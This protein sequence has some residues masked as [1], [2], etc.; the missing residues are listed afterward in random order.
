MSSRR[1]PSSSSGPG[2]A[3]PTDVALEVA[4]VA[5]DAARQI[6]ELAAIAGGLAMQLHGYT[7]NTKDVDVVATRN[8]RL[9]G[10][11]RALSF[12]G[13][14]FAVNHP[15]GTVELDVIV[16]SDDDAELYAA[17]AENATHI[18]GCRVVRPDYLAIMKM[19]AHRPKDELDFDY[20]A[21][22]GLLSMGRIRAIV[23]RHY[24]R[25]ASYIIQDIE[26]AEA[27]AIWHRDHDR[28]K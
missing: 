1:N 4:K 15:W 10:K 9:P 13:H 21:G 20:L 27:V 18:A 22:E 17:A 7:R 28:R 19:L 8:L 3:I 14:S 26:Q 2:K 24:G 12:G 5:L 11:I 23:R 25:G 6:G 16:R